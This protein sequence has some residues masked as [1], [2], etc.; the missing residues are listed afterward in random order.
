MGEGFDRWAHLVD[1]DINAHIGR[2]PSCFGPGH[3][4]A[5]DM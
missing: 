4:A 5:D 1:H 2:L 3:A